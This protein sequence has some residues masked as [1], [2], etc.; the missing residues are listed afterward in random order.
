MSASRNGARADAELLAERRLLAL[1]YIT[2]VAI[3]PIGLIAG[4]VVIVR[5][6]RPLSKHGRWVIAISV[7]AAIVWVLILTSNVINTNTNGLS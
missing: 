6:G 1:A 2:A 4:I 7:V 3:P 5:H